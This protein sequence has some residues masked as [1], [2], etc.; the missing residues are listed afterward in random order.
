MDN[1]L[2]LGYKLVVYENSFH[3]VIAL[4]LTGFTTA[5]GARAYQ[6]GYD[7][8]EVQID[9]D[10]YLEPPN[11]AMNLDLV[12]HS[13]MLGEEEQKA[14]RPQTNNKTDFPTVLLA[15]FFGIVGAGAVIG[16]FNYLISIGLLS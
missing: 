12:Y 15:V 2:G 11:H 9:Y 8:S 16:L 7:Y 1:D 6:C 13:A 5:E 4:E 14:I 10:H 3:S